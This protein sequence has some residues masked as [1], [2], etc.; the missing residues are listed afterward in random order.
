MGVAF[1]INSF[2]VLALLIIIEYLVLLTCVQIYLSLLVLRGEGVIAIVLF[3]VSVSTASVGLSALVPLS[4]SHGV[5]L[6]S[7]FNILN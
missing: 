1:T 5:D 6:L 4:R 2:H 7:V 3:T